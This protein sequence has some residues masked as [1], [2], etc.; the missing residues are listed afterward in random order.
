MGARWIMG[1]V[2]RA[3]IS[4]TIQRLR[5]RERGDK[6]LSECSKFPKDSKISEL[7]KFQDIT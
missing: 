2:Q 7:L 4:V 5:G 3:R 6:S 1:N